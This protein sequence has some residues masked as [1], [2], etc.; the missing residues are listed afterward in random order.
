MKTLL[1]ATDCNPN[2]E[3][4]LKYAHR[5]SRVLKASFHVLHV[6]DLRSFTTA[7]VRSRGVLEKNYFLD[8]LE[9][10]KQYCKEQLKNELGAMDAEFHAVKS[11]NISKAIL[12]TAQDIKADLVIVGVK[13]TKS[14]RGFFTG[15]IAKNLMDKLK[16]PLLILPDDYYLHDISTVLYAT[17]FEPTDV[18]ALK[19]VAKLVESYRALIKVFH[20][21]LKTEVN[22]ENKMEVFKEEVMKKIDYPEIIFSI[23]YADDVESGIH[24][25]IQEEI[26]EML[27]MMEREQPS[28]FDRLFCKD[29]VETIEGKI[30]IPLL[31]F[32]KKSILE[33]YG[34]DSNDTLKEQTMN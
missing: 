23:E 11:T 8:Q 31:V 7:N 19:R 16:S 15:N 10:L 2:T 32:N 9:V 4:A 13:S 24:N 12:K 17:D 26:P 34:Q 22:V 5:L 3:E 21:P 27:V 20:I 14:L 28:F 25:S 30:S 29:T 18:F 1:Y 33:M 6:Y